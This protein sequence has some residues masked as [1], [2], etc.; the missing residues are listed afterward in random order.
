[1]RFVNC[2]RCEDEQ[3]IIA[4]QY[5]GEIFYRVYKEIDADAELLVWYGDE[6]AEQL[7]IPLFEE[8]EKQ[9]E[10]RFEGAYDIRRCDDSRSHYFVK[11]LKF[12]LLFYTSLKNI[13]K[14]MFTISCSVT[15]KVSVMIIYVMTMNYLTSI[16]QSVVT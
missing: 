2:A 10:K 4:Y 14:I 15:K 11:I 16:T 8:E 13:T 1:M 7:G 12:K 5:H 9:E 6:Y 3:N